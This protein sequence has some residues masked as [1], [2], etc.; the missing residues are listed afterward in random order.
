MYTQNGTDIKRL[1]EKYPRGA[2]LTAREL[3][4]LGVSRELQRSYVRSGWLKR[5]GV[6]ACLVLG[7]EMS[8]D[9]ALRALQEGLRLSVH[10]GGYSALGEKHG[11]IHNILASRKAELFGGRGEKLPVWFISAFGDDC[12]LTRTAFLPAELGLVDIDAG[13]FS[14]KVSSAER[15]M[16]ELLY[17]APAT[18]TLREAYQIMEL[19]TTAKPALAQELLEHC[20]SVKVKRLFL[21]MAER[22]GHAWVKRIDLS[23]V[24]LGSGIREIERGGK[25]DRKY[26][27]VVGDLGEI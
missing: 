15:A 13:G 16:L 23:G 4:G 1:L 12:L 3:L 5:V 14:V 26:S 8:L 6:G 22:T 18:H 7:G 27:I 24:D 21:L 9:G 2:V 11:K 17:L 20:T 10:L 19:L 25:L